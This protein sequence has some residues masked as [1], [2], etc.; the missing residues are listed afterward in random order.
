MDYMSNEENILEI[1]RLGPMKKI[2]QKIMP[3]LRILIEKATAQ[4]R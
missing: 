3:K 4:G 1:N 2:Q